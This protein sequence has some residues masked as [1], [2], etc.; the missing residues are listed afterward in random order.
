MFSNVHLID[1]WVTTDKFL[2]LQEHE[3]RIEPKLTPFAFFSHNPLASGVL[4]L[5]ILLNMQRGGIENVNAH[6]QV[7]A[8]AHLYNVLKCE[9]RL[10]TPWQD[11]EDFL[12][13]H[14]HEFLI[15]N[16]PRGR[17][18]AHLACLQMAMEK[19]INSV[20]LNKRHLINPSFRQQAHPGVIQKSKI[21]GAFEGLLCPSETSAATVTIA[22]IETI[23]SQGAHGKEDI[24]DPVTTQWNATHTLP[25]L[26]LL[27]ILSNRLSSEAPKILFN[28]QRLHHTCWTLLS[29][30]END[31]HGEFQ[32]WLSTTPNAP[33]PKRKTNIHL[34]L[35]WLPYYLLL[36]A[37]L[38]RSLSPYIL[39]TEGGGGVYRGRRDMLSRAERILGVFLREEG[40][41]GRG[42]ADGV[43]EGGAADGVVVLGPAVLWGILEGG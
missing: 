27:R 11:M 40:M 43:V 6:R 24:D 16:K 26:D 33:P 38:P 41:D 10:F 4:Q 21:I 2:E 42:E 18:Q 25:P 20:P 39:A 22:D 28:Y 8:M 32:H 7:L 15:D 37:I 19:S 14:G 1:R 36:D 29:D 34:S 3:D 30:I 35:H 23:L 9:E 12:A 17:L 5:G 31:M 13:L